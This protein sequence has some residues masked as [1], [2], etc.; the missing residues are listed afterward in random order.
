MNAPA[1]LRSIAEDVG[2]PNILRWTIVT[3]FVL[4][5][6][7]RFIH[8]NYLGALLSMGALAVLWRDRVHTRSP[9]A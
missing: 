5:F 2:W 1:P 4:L 7:G 9:A 8:D 6:F 3:T